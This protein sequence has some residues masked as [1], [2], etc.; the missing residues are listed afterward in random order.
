M[1]RHVKRAGGSFVIT[2]VL[3]CAPLGSVY[4]QSPV[5]PGSRL[6]TFEILLSDVSTRAGSGRFALV[7]VVDYRCAT[8]NGSWQRLLRGFDQIYINTGIAIH[9]VIVGEDF[10]SALACAGE[11]QRAWEMHLALMA[12][13]S[14]PQDLLRAATVAGLNRIGFMRCLARPGSGLPE[15]QL[16]A[17]AQ[18]G[19]PVAPRPVFF[20]K[21]GLGGVV[22]VEEQESVELANSLP[23]LVEA[24]EKFRKS[25][26]ASAAVVR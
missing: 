6:P 24:F 15:R 7:E 14:E 21:V 12:R 16:H 17:A 26:R 5:A 23:Q 2:G 10:V 20:A 8:C 1:T 25:T 9:I 22:K 18:F 11:Q 4:S 13:L 3:A 19:E